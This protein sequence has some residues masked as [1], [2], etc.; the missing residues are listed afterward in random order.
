LNRDVLRAWLPF[1]LAAAAWGQTEAAMETAERTAGAF[2]IG[3][4]SF[5]VVLRV[6]RLP[7]PGAEETVTAIQ[8]RDAGGSLA[9][10]RTLPYR[11]DGKRFEETTA[12]EARPLQGKKGQGVLLGYSVLPSTPVGGR[13]WQVFGVVDGKLAPLSKPITVEGSLVEE[14]SGKPVTASWDSALEADVLN[15]RVW[16][17]RFFVVVPLTLNWEWGH[18]RPAYPLPKSRWNMEA[19]RQ[20]IAARNTVRLYPSAGEEPEAAEVPIAPGA[21]V[22]LLS[23]EGGIIWEDSEDHIWLSVTENLWLQVRINGK[24]GWLHAPEDFDAIGLPEAG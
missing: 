5:Q 3:E 13:A 6:A 24:E 9:W 20:P 19:G 4:R 18:F 8:V 12:V 16:T 1:V 21:T 15:F 7:Q 17:G 22:E 11:T 14:V 10:E 23:A 2:A